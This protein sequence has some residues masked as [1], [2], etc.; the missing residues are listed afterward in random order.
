M[1]TFN[2]DGCKVTEEMRVGNH[3]K[4]IL[5]LLIAVGLGG[6]KE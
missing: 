5:I 3:P 6:A 4:L 2:R 1:R